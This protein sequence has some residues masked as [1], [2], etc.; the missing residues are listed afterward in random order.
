MFKKFL[1]NSWFCPLFV[2]TNSRVCSEW[3]LEVGLRKQ[4]KLFFLGTDFLR[5]DCLVKIGINFNLSQR[6]GWIGQKWDSF[7]TSLQRFSNSSSLFRGPNSFKILVTNYYFRLTFKKQNSIDSKFS[8]IGFWLA[9]S[10]EEYSSL[11][12]NWRNIGKIK[13][14][15][16]CWGKI[17]K[18]PFPLFQTVFF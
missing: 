13:R 14:K 11:G 2:S 12:I 15:V 5:G 9:C 18:W 16:V 3:C 7:Y 1:H 17:S 10:D 8:H 6:V 4:E